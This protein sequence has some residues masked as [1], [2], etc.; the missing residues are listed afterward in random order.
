[1]NRS[2]V[3]WRLVPALFV[4]LSCSGSRPNP[5]SAQA[6]KGL[7]KNLFSH[8]MKSADV[9]AAFAK[10]Q[11]SW[12]AFVKTNHAVTFRVIAKTRASDEPSGR[13]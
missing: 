4:V 3:V 11:D 1:M 12:D 2:R 8:V 5:A 9:D 6:P 13:R 7:Q 10:I